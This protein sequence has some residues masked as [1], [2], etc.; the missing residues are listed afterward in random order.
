MGSMADS[1]PQNLGFSAS[2]P[3]LILVSPARAEVVG[4]RH[5]GP[6]EETAEESIGREPVEGPNDSFSPPS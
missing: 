6:I 3:N 5:I 1:N 4:R 2:H